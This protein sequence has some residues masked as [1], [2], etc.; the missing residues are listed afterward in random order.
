MSQARRCNLWYEMFSTLQLHKL[1]L[2][3]VSHHDDPRYSGLHLE[4]ATPRLSHVLA[5]ETHPL[6]HYSLIAW[7]YFLE[8]VCHLLSSLLYSFH[9]GYSHCILNL[10]NCSCHVQHT[11]W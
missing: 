3:R 4:S 9:S 8:L 1:R 5:P 11:L 10:Q 7:S 2:S 6:Q